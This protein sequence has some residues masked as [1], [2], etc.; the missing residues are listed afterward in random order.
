MNFSCQV[1]RH[2]ISINIPAS[3]FLYVS[4]VSTWCTGSSTCTSATS[5]RTIWCFSRRR[6]KRR[7]RDDRA[8]TMDETCGQRQIR[9]YWEQGVKSIRSRNYEIGLKILEKKINVPPGLKVL[10]VRRTKNNVVITSIRREI[11]KLYKLDRH[12][13]PGSTNR[14]RKRKTKKFEARTT[15]ETYREIEVSD[16]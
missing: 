7:E 5:W 3:C 12:W 16:C 15:K 4:S 8:C 13:H 1:W 10:R 6:N 14:T 9:K 11:D 2:R